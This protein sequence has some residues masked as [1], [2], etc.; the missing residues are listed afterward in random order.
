MARTPV[1]FSRKAFASALDR[2]VTDRNFSRKLAERPVETLAQAGIHLPAH[3]LRGQKLSEKK[4]RGRGDASK[5]YCFC[6]YSSAYGSA[7]G[8]ELRP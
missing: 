7:F 2:I 4:H 3:K 8:Y 5:R 1:R 6:C